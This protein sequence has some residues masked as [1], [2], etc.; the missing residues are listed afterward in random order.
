MLMS[1][2]AC[3]I[4]IFEHWERTLGNQYV[5]GVAGSAGPKPLTSTVARLNENLLESMDHTLYEEQFQ[6]A[7]KCMSALVC[8]LLAAVSCGPQLDSN[9]FCR[10]TKS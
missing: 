2:T 4:A 1:A 7:P 9:R 5:N 3:S 10:L 8:M 6:V